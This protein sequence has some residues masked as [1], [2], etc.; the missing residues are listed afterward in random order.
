M[1]IRDSLG[2]GNDVLVGEARMQFLTVAQRQLAAVA[3]VALS[4]IHICP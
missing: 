3:V 2:V 4:L 1:C